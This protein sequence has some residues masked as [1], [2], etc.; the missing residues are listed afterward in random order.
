VWPRFG[1][2]KAQPLF[3]DGPSTD[4]YLRVNS[5]ATY[6]IWSHKLDIDPHKQPFL[7]IKWGMDRFPERAA[8]DVDGRHDRPLVIVIS[9]GPK[10][11]SSGLLPDVPRGLAFFWGETETVGTNYTCK[12]LRQQ[13]SKKAMCKYPHVKYIALRRGG[14]GTSHIDRVHLVEVFQHHFPDY[15]ETYR[16]VPPIVAV[17]FEAQSRHTASVSHARLYAIT[18]TDTPSPTVQ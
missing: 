10:V 7:E 16:K 5:K 4:R 15:W 6:F 3:F 8:L 14:A 12:P 13:A 17:S 2:G 1:L 18:F 11:P 9:F